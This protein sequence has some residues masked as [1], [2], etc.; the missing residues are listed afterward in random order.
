MHVEKLRLSHPELVDVIEAARDDFPDAATW[1]AW[2]ELV[3]A[4]W[5]RELAEAVSA[6]LR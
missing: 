4:D 5:E 3:V 1:R 2:A 6:A